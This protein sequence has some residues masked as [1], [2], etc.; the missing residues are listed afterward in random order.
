MR[1]T[2]A[3][4]NTLIAVPVAA[5]RVRKSCEVTAPTAANTAT[6]IPRLTA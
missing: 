1:R 3:T 6:G 2:N 4:A 5:R